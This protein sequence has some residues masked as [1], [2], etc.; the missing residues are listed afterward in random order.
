M[1]IKN[2]LFVLFLLSSTSLRAEIVSVAF[3]E[4]LPPFVLPSTDSGVEVEIVREALKVRGHVLKGVYLPMAR[5]T[6]AFKARRVD[7]IMLDVG[8]DMKKVGGFYGDPP[9]L[10]DNV[11]IT[12][13]KNKIVI[14]NPS[15]LKGLRIDSFVGA[16]KRYP[17]WLG[18][19]GRTLEYVEKNDQSTQPLLLDLERFDVV[20]CDRYIFK[21][22]TML[23][24]KNP[25]FKNLPVVE[26]PFTVA[27]P[28]HYRPVFY[29]KKIRDDFNYG[30]KVIRKKGIDRAIYDSYLKG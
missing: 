8:E 23:A 10:Y 24:K 27:N 28:D 17:K 18:E 16:L 13:K 26:H 22:Y 19:V 12:L 7:V 11:F 2:F 25:R 3:G 6:T 5:I 4:K 30:L 15:D 21:Y 1:K 20:L 9:I 29:S 14:K